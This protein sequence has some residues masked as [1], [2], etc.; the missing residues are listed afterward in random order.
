M[1]GVLISFNYAMTRATKEAY[2]ATPTLIILI[3]HVERENLVRLR[4]NKIAQILGVSPDTV[5]RHLKKLHSLQLILPDDAED[6]R[7][8]A[9]FNWRVCPFLGWKGGTDTL[10]TYL[11]KLPENHTWLSYSELQKE[12]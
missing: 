6:G 11:K 9:I 8:R 10:N 12:E 7:S 2:E 1:K 3:T 5:N 4:P